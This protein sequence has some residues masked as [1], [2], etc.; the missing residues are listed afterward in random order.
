M[1]ALPLLHV[2]PPLPVL[3]PVCAASPCVLP[4]PRV[5]RAAPC[6]S[7]GPGDGCVPCR[8]SLWF[9]SRHRWCSVV[10]VAVVPVPGVGAVPLIVGC[11]CWPLPPR[12]GCLL[13][14]VPSPSFPAICP[15]SNPGAGL[16]SSFLW[17]CLI[18]ALARCL[19]GA[20]SLLFPP[21]VCVVSCCPL[22]CVAAVP[23]PSAVVGAHW[24]LLSPLSLL[25]PSGPGPCPRCLIVVV[26]VA[27]SSSSSL[28]FCPRRPHRAVG[29]RRAPVVVLR[30]CHT[31]PGPG[32]RRHRRCLLLLLF[33]FLFLVFVHSVLPHRCPLPIVRVWV[34][35]VFLSSSWCC[36]EKRGG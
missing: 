27:P 28:P 1:R 32:L 17:P 13:V 29:A 11:S 8:P 19:G 15:G 6:L 24:Y 22:F 7:S 33:L 9:S 2:P 20:L 12:R 36:L 3:P 23:A 10:P 35:V 21:R 26:V 16:L 18:V 31:P 30:W 5:H 34:V 4:G 25:S 14:V